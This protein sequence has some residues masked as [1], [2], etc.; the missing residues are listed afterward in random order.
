MK[1]GALEYVR[2]EKNLGFFSDAF[3]ENQLTNMFRINFGTTGK[4]KSSK[5]Y[6]QSH[7]RFY[8]HTNLKYKW[9]TTIWGMGIEIAK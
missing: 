5:N 4:K 1:A 3:L 8:Q 6:S 7:P 2:Y 9:N